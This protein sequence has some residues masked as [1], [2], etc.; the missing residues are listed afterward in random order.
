[1]ARSDVLTLVSDF[2]LS[3]TDATEVGVLYDEVVRELGFTEVLT[4]VEVQAV[5]AGQTTVVFATDTIR[6]LELYSSQRGKLDRSTAN[7]ARTIFGNSWRQQ[8][9]PP[10][11]Y[12]QDQE[13]DNTVRLV[14]IPTAPLSV[15]VIRVDARTDVPVWL[16]LPLALEIVSRELSRESDHQDTKFAAG[17]AQ[18]GRLLF[19]MLD[20]EFGG[21]AETSGARRQTRRA[22]QQ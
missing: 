7:A 18:L 8:V 6:S 5:G 21:R 19:S 3:V 16:E 22:M 15:S 17:A 9:G 14:P 10:V 1:M 12:V 11:M 13:D 20:V 4:S 2:G